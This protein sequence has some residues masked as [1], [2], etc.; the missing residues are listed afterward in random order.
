MSILEQCTKGRIYRR[1][2]GKWVV[3]VYS[4]MEAIF[5]DI[6]DAYTFYG[7]RCDPRV[8]DYGYAPHQPCI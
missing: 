3:E 8:T 4:W 7:E 6:E 2:D 5:Y 1:N